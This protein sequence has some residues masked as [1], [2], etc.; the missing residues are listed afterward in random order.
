MLVEACPVV[1][2]GAR[3]VLHDTCDIRVVSEAQDVEAACLEFGKCRPTVVV[4]EPRMRDL[5]AFSGL[6]LIRRLKVMNAAVRILV[7]SDCDD[8]VTTLR[9]FRL[10]AI[11]YLA[12]NRA[13]NHLVDAVRTVAG[14]EYHLE[15]PR[16]AELLQAAISGVAAGPLEKLTPRELQL[17]HHFA[18]G[19]STGE[20]AEGFSISPK[21][22]GVHHTAI[23]KKLGLRSATELVRLAIRC[24]VIDP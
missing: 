20:I 24:E 22:V 18:E 3:H 4:I 15:T 17:F 21:T 16:A 8:D 12:K 19:R 14:G 6:E 9:A 10:G 2:E 1:R 13:V 23:M 11:G 5:N 7:F